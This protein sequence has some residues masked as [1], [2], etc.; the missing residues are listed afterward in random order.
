MP[1]G[2]SGK[3]A[4]NILRGKNPEL[5]GNRSELC[6]KQ[7]FKLNKGIINDLCSCKLCDL[8]WQQRKKKKSKKSY[9]KA[10]ETICKQRSGNEDPVWESLDLLW[11]KNTA[12]W[13]KK[14]IKPKPKNES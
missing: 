6:F 2:T 5:T 1:K 7:H 12:V 14:N 8:N 13:G 11:N 3:N 9:A 10:E 4:V